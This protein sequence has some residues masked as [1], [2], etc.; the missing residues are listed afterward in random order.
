[1]LHGRCQGVSKLCQLCL[2]FNYTYITTMKSRKKRMSKV[3]LIF[4]R[5]KLFISLIAPICQTRYPHLPQ[6]LNRGKKV[7]NIVTLCIHSAC[8]FS[9]SGN[10]VNGTGNFHSAQ[11]IPRS[12]SY[13][14]HTVF[15]TEWHRKGYSTPYVSIEGVI[16]GDIC[17]QKTHFLKVNKDKLSYLKKCNKEKK[18][19]VKG[20]RNNFSPISK[21]GGGGGMEIRSKSKL[22]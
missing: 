2:K 3:D 4:Q 20:P 17:S 15:P 14:N 9:F 8:Q 18:T 16:S 5:W 19:G 11:G 10:E 1:M 21:L 22:I 6:S 7:I 13:I 12:V